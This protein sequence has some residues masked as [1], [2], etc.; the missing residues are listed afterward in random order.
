MMHQPLLLL[1]KFWSESSHI[2]TQSPYNVT[3]VSRIDCLACQNEFFVNNLLEVK[4]ND[5]HALDFALY[6]SH[7]FGLNEY[8]LSMYG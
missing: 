8:G 7:L 1:P 2:F 4:E 5:E 3:V 6:Q